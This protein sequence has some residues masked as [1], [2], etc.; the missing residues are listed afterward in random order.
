MNIKTSHRTKFIIEYLNE[1]W[2]ILYWEGC[3]VPNPVYG[4]VFD[5]SY[6]IWVNGAKVAYFVVL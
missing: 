1:H 4:Y 6:Y 5:I 3:Q 2:I